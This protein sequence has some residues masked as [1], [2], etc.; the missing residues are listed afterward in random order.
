MA[1]YYSIKTYSD[2]G[3]LMI[4]TDSEYSIKTITKQYKNVTKNLDIIK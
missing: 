4:V 1:I 2:K 3:K